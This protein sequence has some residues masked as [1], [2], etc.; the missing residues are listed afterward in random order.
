MAANHK[1][2]VV[3]GETGLCVQCA[4]YLIN[5]G[6]EVSYVVSLDNVVVD[7]AKSKNIPILPIAQLSHLPTDCF[8][9]F[10]I[11]NPF[12]IPESVLTNKRL[13]L[14]LNYHDSFLPRYAGVNSTTWAII[15]G[16]KEH[17]VTFHKIEVGIDEGDIVAQSPIPI[18]KD[19]TAISLNLKC[20]ERFL[21]LFKE[22]ITKIETDKL[23]FIKQDIA[24]KTYYGL[25]NLPANYGIINGIKDIYI[26]YDLTR[27]LTFG[28]NYN[29]P[30]A[31]VKVN[32][33]N[34]F[35]IAEDFNLNTVTKDRQLSK[36][37]ILF[38]TVRDVYGNKTDLK[39]THKDITTTYSLPN[40]DLQFLA[41]IKAQERKVKQQ[42][43]EFFKNHSDSSI[44]VLGHTSDII[45]GQHYRK[46]VS[47]TKSIETPDILAL[48]CFIL[49]RFFREDFIISL[50]LA[51]DKIPPPL[52]N[53]VENRGFIALQQNLLDNNFSVLK[54][55]LTS[56]LKNSYII[57][58]DFGYRYQ[59]QLLTDIAITIGEAASIDKH[60]LVIK[61]KDHK[62]EFCGD[63]AYKLQID[64]LAE[65]IKTVIT[66]KFRGKLATAKLKHIS[67]L[68]EVQ[69]KKIV[70]KWNDTEQNYPIDKTVHQLFEEQ[71]L[72]T[73]SNLAI[74]YKDKKLTYKELNKE[75]NKLANYLRLNYKVK[76]DSLVVLFLDITDSMII[77]MLGVLKAGGAYIPIDP[78]HPDERIGYIL[79]DTKTTLIL[80]SNTHQSR[81]Q[82]LVNKKG[83]TT[84]ILTIDSKPIQNELAKREI[85][86]PEIITKNNNL[87]Y[88]LYTS[89]TTGNP[90]GVM[91]EHKGIVSLVKGTDYVN[92]SA[93]DAFFQLCDI[94]F[95]FSAFEI[96]TPLLNGAKLVIP[97]DRFAL[98]S[99]IKLFHKALTT[100][101][102]TTLLMTKTLLDQLFLSDES[103]FRD[104]KYLLVG[105][106][107]LSKRL[108]DK[109]MKSSYAPKN[110]I[111][112]YG[113]TEN[114][115][116]CC[117][118]NIKKKNLI[119]IDTVPI[120]TPLSNRK[121]YV[122]DEDLN[123]LPI[124][125]TGELYVAGD[126]IARGYLNKPDL[127]KEK[128]IDNLWQ[129]SEEKSKNRNGKLYK[130]GDLVR[131]LADGNLEY[132]GRN[133]EQIKIRGFRVELGDIENK[134]LGYP[135]IKQAVVLIKERI[136]KNTDNKYLL[137]YYI[138]DKKLDE[139]RIQAYLATQLPEY[140]VP[141]IFV[142]LNKLPLTA[143]G[144][145]NKNL[146][147]EPRFA[148][149][150]DH[151]A[152]KTKLQTQLVE[153]WS[154]ALDFPDQTIGITDDFFKLG[155][156]SITAIK[157]ISVI[158]QKFKA[159]IQVRDIL[160][161]RTIENLEK[162]ISNNIG[163]FVFSDY[164]IKSSDS[165][166][167]YES[168]ELTN[169][170]QAYY[171][172][173]FK[174]FTL[175]NTSVHLYFEYE[176]EFLHI[177]NL[178]TALNKLIMRHHNLRMV[179]E[180]GSQRYIEH[181]P[182]YQV[183]V[184]EL[185]GKSELESIREEYSHKVYAN[186][187]LWLFDIFVSTFKGKY[188][189]HLSIDALIMDAYSLWI[190]L[191]ELGKLYKNPLSK[192][193]KITINYRDYIKQ[194]VAIR[195]G[196]LFAKAKKYWL[197]RTNN[198]NFTLALPLQKQP[199]TIVYPKFAR[200]S[201][202][203]DAKI[204]GAVVAKAK[205]YGISQTIL[206]LCVYGYVL[207]YWS[208]QDKLCI[209]LTLFNRLPLHEQINNLV[210]DFTTLELFNY[211]NNEH[212]TK[213]N[214]L[215]LFK[216]IHDSL[217]E[218]IENN[219]FDGVD[220]QRLVRDNFLTSNKIVA[221]V[222][223]TSIFGVEYSSNKI[224]DDSCCGLG[225]AIT[226]T[227]Q[228]WLDNKAYER[229]GRFVAEWD[230]VEE[231]FNKIDIEAMHEHYLSLIQY[232]AHADWEKDT[233]PELELP[234]L[235]EAI[236]TKANIAT[237]P[238]SE[239]TLFNRYEALITSNK[240]KDEI[241][242]V[243]CGK[244]REY[245]YQELFKDSNLIARF[246]LAFI[247]SYGSNKEN[248]IDNTKLVAILSDKG[249]NHVLGTTSIMKADFGY[250][251]LNVDWPL[252]RVEEILV[253]AGTKVLLISREEYTNC[254]LGRDKLR[255]KY[256][257]IVIE[258]V[259][260][261]LAQNPV[262]RDDLLRTVLP[263]VFAD[264]VAYVIF[265]SGS[266]GI[267]KGVTI[268]HRGAMNTI[269]AINKEFGITKKDGVLAISELG[270]DLSVY[271]IFG[272]L[273]VGGKIIFPIQ[274]RTKEPEYWLGLIEKH[275]ATVWN[276]VPQLASLLI[277]ELGNSNGFNISALR[278]F[279]L[280]GDWLPTN[281][282]NRIKKYCSQAQIISLGG[283]TEGSIW[284]IWYKINKVYSEWNSIPYGVAMPN[285]K[286]YVLNHAYQHCPV[287]VIGEIYIGGMGVA[288]NYWR[289][290]S[291]T[292]AS[293][294]PH[295]Q[296]GRI[297]R[298]GDLGKWN[299]NG[300]IE[301]MGRQD[302]QIKVRGYRV[303]L[304][305]IEKK[306][307][308]Y[309]KITQAIV[310]AKKH[311]NRS[312]YL[313][314]YYVAPTKLSEE[315]IKVAL[316]DKLPDYMVPN[317][318]VH[319]AQLPLTANGKL[320]LAVLDTLVGSP[321]I[322]N[323]YVAPSSK[324]E[325]RMCALYAEVFELP[326]DKVGI[327]DDFFEMGGD[328]IASM[329]LVSRIRE[330]LKLQITIQDIFNQR[331]IEELVKN[332]LIKQKPTKENITILKARKNDKNINW[333]H[334]DKI[335]KDPKVED[336][337]FAN[338]LHE[339]FIYH[340][341]RNKK[342]NSDYVSHFLWKYDTEIDID[343][344]EKAWQLVQ[345]KYPGLRLRFAWDEELVQI[346][347]KK[348]EI[349]FKYIDL[350]SLE[351]NNDNDCKSKLTEIA[352]KLYDSYDL[353]EGKLFR[354]CLV[355]FSSNN[356][357]SICSVHHGIIDAWSFRLLFDDAHKLYLQ[358]LNNKQ[359]QIIEDVAYKKAQDY[360]WEHKDRYQRY[361]DKY[362]AQIEDRANL[363]PLLKPSVSNIEIKNH[364]VVIQGKEQRLELKG[365]IFFR[366]KNLCQV[367]G[368][369]INAVIQYVW[370]KILHIYGA[371]NTT[372][373]GT[374]VTIRNIPIDNIEKSVG[375]FINTL[376]LI[377][378]HD[379]KL[380]IIE[381]IKIIQNSISE[382]GDKSNTGLARLQAG[383]RL[384]DSL[385]SYEN[386]PAPEG[387]SGTM[388]DTIW[389][390]F[391]LD[392]PLTLM[393]HEEKQTLTIH[394][395]YAGELFSSNTIAYL[396]NKLL[397][398]IEQILENPNKKA[399]YYLSPDEYQSIVV[400]Y[401]KTKST[402]LTSKTI[403]QLFEEQALRTPDNIA[404]AYK[405]KK[406][407]YENLNNQ[408]NQLAHY[409]LKNNEIKPE[410]LIAI[411]LDR[412]EYMLLSTLAV[413]KTGAAYIP[414]DPNYPA[415]RIKY[416][417]EDT[418]AKLVIK[419]KSIKCNL[420]DTNVIEVNSEKT[421]KNL[422][423]NKTS[424]PKIKVSPNN[425]IYV[426]YTSGTT[427][428]P[429]G[430]LIEHRSVVN[431][432]SHLIQINQLNEQTAGSQYSS[433]GFDAAVIEIYPVLLS[434][435]TISIIK[436]EDKLD[437]QKVN[438]FFEENKITYAFLPTQFAEMFLEFQ[439]S[440]L[441]NL[442]IG[443]DKLQ[444][445]IPQSYQIINAYGPT[446]ATV[447]SNYFIVKQQYQN[448]PIGKPIPNITNYVL[449]NNLS[450]LPIGTVGE[451]YIGGMGVARGY[452]NQKQLTTDKFIPNPFQTR[453]EKFKKVNNL[454]F[455]TG[456][457]VK[458][459]PDGNIEY[460]GRNDSQVKIRG[461][462]IELEEIENNLLNYPGI[463]QSVVIV[464]KELQD[465]YLIV[466]YVADKI[467]NE[468]EIE[469]YLA[470]QLPSYMI[471]RVFIH[472]EKL[473]LTLSG[474]LDKKALPEPIFTNEDD[475]LLPRSKQEELICNAFANIL[476]LK[477]I[478]IND[479][480]FLL[481][482]NSI[483]AI[484]LASMLQSNFDIKVA[485]IF[486]FR[487][488][489]KLARGST[490]G[491]NFLQ[492]KLEKVKAAYEKENNKDK[493]HDTKTQE[494][495][496][497]YI[498]SF[499]K[500]SSNISLKK[501]I[502]NV[503]LSG[504]TGYLGCNILNQLLT[505]TDYKIYLLIRANSQLEATEKV[506]KKYL[507]YFD[508]LLNDNLNS[509]IFIIKADIEEDFMGLSS[510]EYQ[511]LTTTVDSVIHTAALVK[512]YGEYDKFYSANVKA[513]HNLLEFTKLTKQKDFHY[514]STI[515]VLNYTPIM[516]EIKSICTEDDL[517]II[518]ETSSNIYV[519][520]KL[521]GEHLV[522]KYQNLGLQCNI[523]RV[524]N[525]AFMSENYHV[526][527]NISDN[528][529][530][531]WL[532]CIFA[533]KSSAEEINKVEMSQTDLTAQAIVKIFDKI[534]L[535]NQTY[536][537]FNPHLFYITDVFKNSDIKML[538]I[539][540]FI[541]LIKQYIKNGSH[542]DLIVKFLLR[543]GWLDLGEIQIVAPMDI[544]QDRT[545]HILKKLNFEWLP[546]NSKVVY[547]YLD[548]LKLTGNIAM[549]NEAK[550]FDD[551]KRVAYFIP[552]PIVW[553]DLNGYVLGLNEPALQA[554]GGKREDIIGKSAHDLYPKELAD[555]MIKNDKCVLKARRALTFEESI[556]DVTT[557]K[558][559][560]FLTTRGPLFDDEGIEI[561]GFI[562]S[563]TEIT[564]HKENER[565]H[566]ENE[567]QKVKLQEQFKL[568]KIIDQTA[569]DIQSPLAILLV[570]SQNCLG[571]T[572]DKIFDT[573]KTFVAF[574]PV[575]TFWLDEKGILIGA[576]NRAVTAI[577]VTS[578]DELIGKT[579]YDIYPYDLADKIAKHNDEVIK[580]GKVLSQE[581]SIKDISSGEIKYFTVF[582]APLFDDNEN[583]IGLVGTMVDITAEKNAE[584]LK[585][586]TL[587]QKAKIEE[588]EK[589]RKIAD[590][591]VHDI[592]SPLTSL[593]IRLQI[594]EKDIPEETRVALRAAAMR[595]TDISNNLLNQYKSEDSSLS[596]LEKRQ[597]VMLS[598]ALLQ[599]L[600]EKRDQY[601]GFSV[602]F[603]HTFCSD[604]NF[605]F[606]RINPSSFDRM[607]SNLINN[608]VD[609][610]E[611]KKGVINL[612]LG[613]NNGDIE[614]MVSDNGKGMPQEVVNKIM[615]GIAI[616]ANKNDGHGIGF[617]QIRETLEQSDGK[618]KINSTV[619]K[620]TEVILTFPQV[621]PPKLLATKIKLSKGDTIV[622]LDD[623][624]SIHHAWRYRF[625][626]YGN[627]I[628][629]VHFTYGDEAIA[630]I[631]K[632]PQKEKI[633]LLTDFELLNQELNG[634]DIID[635]TKIEHTILVTS[636][637]ANMVVHDLATKIGTKILPK[638][639]A[640]EVPIEIIDVKSEVERT[641]KARSNDIGNESQKHTIVKSD[642]NN[643]QKANDLKKIDVVLI[644]DE[645]ML[646]NDLSALLETSG[647]VVDKYYNPRKFLAN[648]A[649]YAKD[650]KI[651]MDND[652]KSNI[653]GIE[654]AK[655]LYEQGYTKLYLFSGKIFA[656]KELPEYL[657][658]I[659]KAE[660]DKFLS[661]V[662]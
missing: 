165:K 624:D 592:Q 59:L 574:I 157:A 186:E 169:V 388:Y 605:L 281:L 506:N 353:R 460:Q 569:H 634:L 614:I 618:I 209:N 87:I 108:I 119:N 332:V 374:V 102:I 191:D 602:N 481:G 138:T 620:G 178:E 593:K 595:I 168:F 645:K 278:L 521:L 349:A 8:Y 12:L 81:L 566:V 84:A 97:E 450:P 540:A 510:S 639:L 266:T 103:V 440:S 383:E 310:L 300:Y 458:M 526:Q 30:I 575:S 371:S 661:F 455:K 638:P 153:I 362:L 582:K 200:I 340:A 637:H 547:N 590:K 156:S 69:Y 628:N 623:D 554:I 361:W 15:N 419:G 53:L 106:E 446:E 389:S 9:L 182:H 560:Y 229:A 480:F 271:D 205:H 613:V 304:G 80:T 563:A 485:D 544:L 227:P 149:N 418:K 19:E 330:Q 100:N 222:V 123:P 175:G 579:P 256:L 79:N 429:K 427:G 219:L 631:N 204:W 438:K 367:N 201:K 557:G 313:V 245:S 242:V 195:Q 74:I 366:L 161:G 291:K 62:I 424:N 188:I 226:Q 113:P 93:S 448:I 572:K 132:L 241:A 6:W 519:Q 239:E 223:L 198:Y 444:T 213:H 35:Y 461:Y 64:S 192:L 329:R 343:K 478:G 61:I 573:L 144:K 394:F 176:F 315:A 248:F 422:S 409:L 235:S 357:A 562:E 610:C 350:S 567:L 317:I 189:L 187:Q 439:N 486:E 382:I 95:D 333:R 408:A 96:W 296:L 512:H 57:T 376:P 385:I 474:K 72:K 116:I 23:E 507:F 626:K 411:I 273:A 616:T 428:K 545:Q 128:F 591:V 267:P 380:G 217:W 501:P 246:L 399:L 599:L 285:Q 249:Y 453:E 107:A 503:L 337:Y 359:P 633:F 393:I 490:F 171:F 447:Q 28:D 89:G 292:E 154:K 414:I 516:R 468:Q 565:L 368:I 231:L 98:F 26:V 101:K 247:N 151:V 196:E 324:L 622:I 5:R 160:N 336:V 660:I 105:G 513:T 76:P 136:A 33:K 341:I 272:I 635:K 46:K 469:S 44:K 326:K 238:S 277:D 299:I 91:I 208:N 193:P 398:F 302:K 652:F 173:K 421:L 70:Y 655:Q 435:G 543:Q 456:D 335:R 465:K 94:G 7:W 477:K 73:P 642:K 66:K 230:Y 621:D 648:L 224:L 233:L 656:Q 538:P 303:E 413:L 464:R 328:S 166:Y 462:R 649:Q 124:G 71:V 311:T 142:H 143:S 215:T 135:Q 636:H 576:N 147:P 240:L 45:D 220:F 384:F 145:L 511:H 43:L 608:A 180:N 346:I 13:L 268:S 216:N 372:V 484:K 17:G 420:P 556:V 334:L 289:D 535:N 270:F 260:E 459:L 390:G 150:Y 454:L 179:I 48:V 632:F 295:P 163:Q 325:H 185:N 658:V 423:K 525:L 244:N 607:M 400:D 392:Y 528:A 518:S 598:L 264:D 396:L 391:K 309:P 131:W 570:I 532:K 369:T 500:T 170:Q 425:L 118:L 127:T 643:D 207:S 54:K 88:V 126:G 117:T 495:L 472:L 21:Q 646:V 190:F 498:S 31:T 134:L 604:C 250:L 99:N 202:E 286:M 564:E 110:V 214:L 531:N 549:K 364:K 379:H 403:H 308:E 183:K 475:Y 537:I 647:K 432:V 203:L 261:L 41:S 344:F 36:N 27:G 137:A 365:P 129:S 611:G 650:T 509:R 197:D 282:P 434:G 320:D 517:P 199:E 457:L 133:D 483:L 253:Q 121:A 174:N 228:V 342:T 255:D 473:P 463:K 555:K 288:L 172:G 578:A 254:K 476:N 323:N 42:V 115:V 395:R 536:H 546:I 426:I 40:K 470:K 466:Y 283:A 640:S 407:T 580:T 377:F 436:D 603:N 406:L 404:V 287:G 339:G 401:N 597:S 2:A 56:S 78:K 211:V 551:L 370:H 534:Y 280:S 262:K 16:E 112:A 431:Y 386:Y 354:V 596:V 348:P 445:F 577:G 662:C 141:Q 491:K 568:R 467:L 210:G 433:F 306:L 489:K 443:G 529:F 402:H 257:L 60:K 51:N 4:E 625:K 552:A 158:N 659:S 493:N 482:G 541:D 252:A 558:T 561:V 387:N 581:E 321:T 494:E 29:N 25:K 487:T 167:L 499:K 274:S 55:Y 405:G 492:Y 358:L 619:D 617:M 508:R 351:I 65:T 3:V 314:A 331:N 583:I 559:K 497:D 275:Q 298:T 417:L 47:F 83:I 654:L 441:K 77:S 505:Q 86:N 68:S 533:I 155:G 20:S 218:D 14:A 305:E 75:A 269:N 164:V 237:Q 140:M 159:N 50:Y 294:I 375:L 416:I 24:K 90:K 571:L 356:Y 553:V 181:P 284:S 234:K 148:G 539:E 11:I 644:D 523:Y 122:L 488:P 606:I 125:I 162:L 243:D 352:N 114:S 600:S 322:N 524:G 586:E 109:L 397:F 496:D 588:H 82:Q 130:T 318:L 152:P 355:K 1:K 194:F 653:T 412:D 594:S 520:T 92:V 347:D 120:G 206:T 502:Q 548:V 34:N 514:I 251:P 452:L 641:N 587:M 584:Q 316:K 504:A 479:D 437:P 522:T 32:L 279:L 258:D 146:L 630:F 63:E 263:Q 312:Q 629:L 360:L 293:F 327:R 225:Y 39:I 585:L 139:S 550:I 184:Y 415:A 221:P 615:N 259:L 651:F 111:N 449:D 515:G 381:Q 58:K 85:A 276:T 612:T 22:V 177:Q 627:D 601:K 338:N 410:D 232:L 290:R 18:E 104:I 609:A 319:L 378:K 442:I 37:I 52:K 527:E 373:V 38:N 530:Y 307:L 542:H 236:I 430:V 657:T 471:P 67:I 297:Y 49:A 212:G 265:T 10:S 345:Q 363:R 589:A 451:L 301:F